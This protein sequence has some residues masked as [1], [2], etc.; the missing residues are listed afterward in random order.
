MNVI[1]LIIKIEIELVR[2]TNM[3]ELRK[4]KALALVALTKNIDKSDSAL[5]RVKFKFLDDG[6]VIV[7]YYDGSDRTIIEMDVPKNV[8]IEHREYGIHYS[9]VLNQLFSELNI[10]NNHELCIQ[11]WGGHIRVGEVCRIYDEYVDN[12]IVLTDEMCAYIIRKIIR[13]LSPRIRDMQQSSSSSEEEE[14]N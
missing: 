3:D 11:S 10:P 9:N 14:E 6:M 7:L 4:Y 2:I 13:E 8:V 5:L 12:Y 1:V